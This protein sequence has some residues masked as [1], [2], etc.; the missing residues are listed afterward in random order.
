MTTVAVELPDKLA[1]FVAA[2]MA[3]Q[4]YASPG[5]VIV[6]LL[7]QLH[8]EEHQELENKLLKGL[9]S[10]DRGDGRPMTNQDWDRLRA[11]IHARYGSGQES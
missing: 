5:E 11:E 3:A 2:R 7:E 6:A 4:G 8:Q 10:L 9:S 1:Q